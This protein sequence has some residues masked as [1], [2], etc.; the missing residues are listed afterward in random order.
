MFAVTGIDMR[1][2]TGPDGRATPAPVTDEEPGAR[3]TQLSLAEICRR[4]A[5]S[6]KKIHAK[7]WRRTY[8]EFRM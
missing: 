2:S 6:G 3:W 4:C 7:S 5:G 8:Q 1:A